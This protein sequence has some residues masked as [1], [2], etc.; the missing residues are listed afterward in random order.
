MFD[1]LLLLKKGGQTVFFGDIGHNATALSD[2][3][4]LIE[5]LKQVT[6]NTPLDGTLDLDSLLQPEQYLGET[7]KIIDNI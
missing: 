1:R 6:K 7:G 4:S 2:E 3:K 5:V